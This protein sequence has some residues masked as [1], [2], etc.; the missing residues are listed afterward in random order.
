MQLEEA[1]LKSQEA[2]VEWLQLER[3]RF[4]K[5]WRQAEVKRLDLLL[6]RRS[7]E[8]AEAARLEKIRRIR[9]NLGL[10]FLRN[11]EKGPSPK[12]KLRSLS[13]NAAGSLS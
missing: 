7:L 2:Y 10:T 8:L 12:R 1:R 3:L 11:S 4:N 6:H 5:V 9:A 13:G